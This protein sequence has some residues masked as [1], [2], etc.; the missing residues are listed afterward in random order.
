MELDDLKNIWQKNEQ[1]HVTMPAKDASEI[2][3]MAHQ[4]AKGILSRINKNFYLDAVILSP[5]A[6]IVVMGTLLISRPDAATIIVS[7]FTL[8]YVGMFY[9][10]ISKLVFVKNTLTDNLRLSLQQ[11]IARLDKMQKLYMRYMLVLFPVV[12][13]A[14]LLAS[15]V[16]DHTLG[17]FTVRDITFLTLSFLSP[18]ILYFPIKWVIYYFY[19]KHIKRLQNCLKEYEEVA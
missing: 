19:G 1:E 15:K 12:F 5:L 7:I 3:Q 13:P 17:V 4:K 16:S 2:A 11:N 10:R 9:R 18:I 6:L 8:A 14:A